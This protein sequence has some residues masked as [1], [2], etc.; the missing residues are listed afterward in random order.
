MPMQAAPLA[1]PAQ[2]P[3]P[4]PPPPNA[5]EPEWNAGFMDRMGELL[6]QREAHRQHHRILREREM[7][8]LAD[9]ANMRENAARVNPHAAI[10][11]LAPGIPPPP[12]PGPPLPAPMVVPAPAHPVEPVPAR[13]MAVANP[14][15]AH[16]QQPVAP[17]EVRDA[18]AEAAQIRIRQAMY[19]QRLRRRQEE[20]RRE[21]MRHHQNYR[22]LADHI[23]ARRAD[24]GAPPGQAEDQARARVR[25]FQPG[26]R[27]HNRDLYHTGGDQRGGG[28]ANRADGD[29]HAPG[30]NMDVPGDG[31]HQARQR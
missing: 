10:H 13:V 9:L 4:P 31:Q 22:Q 11:H 1:Q 12:A 5:L 17:I 21:I 24:E 19:T 30:Q 15:V 18:Q 14:A 26:A 25:P 27:P 16:Q 2:P 7:Q 23:E 29:Q 6:R 20:R 28:N 8:A 3:P